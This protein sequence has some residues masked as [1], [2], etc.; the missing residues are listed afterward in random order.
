MESYQQAGLG[1]LEMTPIYGVK[2]HE[3]EFIPYLS[4]QWM[5]MLQYTL[6]RS[7]TTEYGH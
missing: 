7:Q 3:S 1:G 5:D 4:P 2:G 6:A